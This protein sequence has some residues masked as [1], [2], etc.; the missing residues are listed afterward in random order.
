MPG[1]GTG[2]GPT[3]RGRLGFDLSRARLPEGQSEGRDGGASMGPSGGEVGPLCLSLYF[4]SEVHGEVI[5]WPA[6][7]MEGLCSVSLK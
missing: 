2:A 7:R 4:L 3:L 1:G 5:Y 6:A